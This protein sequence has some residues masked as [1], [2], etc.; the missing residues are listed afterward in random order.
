MKVAVIKKEKIEVQTYDDV[1][2]ISNADVAGETIRL[3]YRED[4]TE[5]NIVIS[6]DEYRM[7]LLWE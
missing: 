2:S 7:V 3:L 5:H 6:K 4:G 1:Y